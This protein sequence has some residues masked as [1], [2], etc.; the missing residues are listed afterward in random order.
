[1]SYLLDTNHCICLLNGWDKPEPKQ[2]K[3]EARIIEIFQSVRDEGVYLSEVSL[4]ELYFGAMLSHQKEK[5][6]ARVN[7]FKRA[8]PALTL[9][10]Q[11]WLLFGE[12]K[13]ELQKQGTKIPD[14]DLLIAVTAKH[15]S[16]KIATADKHLLKLLP[17]SFERE[18]WLL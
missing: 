4:G 5:S 7:G 1:M 16:L 8:I 14:F 9:T 18:N 12:I 15:H 10:D 3:K 11:I 2:T 13:A 17:D 6:L